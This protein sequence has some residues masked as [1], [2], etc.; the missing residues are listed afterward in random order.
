MD[1]PLHLTIEEIRGFP[2]GTILEVVIKWDRGKVGTK[3]VIDSTDVV[4]SRCLFNWMF[5]LE[6]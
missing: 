6:V 2:E 1:M 3:P 5:V 4:A